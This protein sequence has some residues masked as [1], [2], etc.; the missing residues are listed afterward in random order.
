MLQS[1][2]PRV[3]AEPAALVHTRGQI[4]TALLKVCAEQAA[5]MHA[6]QAALLAVRAEHSKQPCRQCLQSKPPCQRCL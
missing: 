6:E 3:H 5:L 1:K 2:Q 4:R